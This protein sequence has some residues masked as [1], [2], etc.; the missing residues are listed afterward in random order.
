MYNFDGNYRRQPVQNLGGSSVVIDRETLIKNVQMQ[1]QKRAELRLQ[2]T[3][4]TVVQ[5]YY[6]SYLARQMIKGMERKCFDDC[7]YPQGIQS[8]QQFEYLLTRFLFFYSRHNTADSERLV[9]VFS[10]ALLAA[11][12]MN[13][14]NFHCVF[15]GET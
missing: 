9:S 2:N 6:R 11:P 12:S 10:V 14:N 1:R 4:A 3:A 15:V 8:I 5:S 13:C 7:Y